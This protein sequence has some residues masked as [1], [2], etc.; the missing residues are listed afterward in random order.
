MDY[1]NIKSSLNNLPRADNS[2]VVAGHYCLAQAMNEL[3]HESET[4]AKSFEVGV[5][6]VSDALKRNVQSDLVLWVN[7]IA[8]EPS[9]RLTIKKNYRIPD[10]YAAIISQYDLD[11]TNV[12]VFFESTMRNK[13]SVLL[14]KLYKRT[15]E[16]FKKVSASQSDLVRCIDTQQCGF[17]SAEKIAYVVN[18]PDGESLV[19]KEGSNPK[20]NLILA[21]LFS[22]LQKKFSSSSLINVFNTVYTYRLK[23]GIHVSQEILNSDIT[24]HNIFCDGNEIEYEFS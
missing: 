12:T 4:E 21:V 16:L 7:D 24:F 17:E 20:C 1:T 9:R 6:L 22:D 11:E 8:I 5:R 14:R 23:L 2:I 18:G 15:P 10:N 13:A 19:V 3:S